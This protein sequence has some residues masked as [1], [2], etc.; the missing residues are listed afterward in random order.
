MFIASN[1]INVISCDIY[2]STNVLK[3][4][5]EIKQFQFA[6]SSMTLK[7]FGHAITENRNFVQVNKKKNKQNFICSVSP[8][9]INCS[10]CS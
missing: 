4:D 3:I 2:K 9:G 1:A 5:V 8:D 10:N 7:Y 6:K